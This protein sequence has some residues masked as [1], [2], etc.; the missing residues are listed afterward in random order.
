MPPSEIQV[1]LRERAEMLRSEITDSFKSRDGRREQELS[2]LMR[3]ELGWP[4]EGQH[5]GLA[6]FYSRENRR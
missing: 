1:L 5:D 6:H 3:H 4:G 2:V